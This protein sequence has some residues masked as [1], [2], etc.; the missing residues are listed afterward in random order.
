MDVL[1]RLPKHSSI[2]VAC[3]GGPDSVAL[4]HKLRE[5]G[6]THKFFLA[7][8]NHKLRGAQSDGD[9]RFVKKLA[10]QVGWPYLERT[11][12]VKNKTGNL[13]ENARITRYE[14]LHQM[15]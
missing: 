8:V 11:R 13:E 7:H 4:V 14:A 9:A 5:S 10:K 15:A 1:N 12:P 2:L 6:L 3:S